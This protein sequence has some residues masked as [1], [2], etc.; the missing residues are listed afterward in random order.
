MTKKIQ[1][2]KKEERQAREII[3]SL[4][5]KATLKKIGKKGMRELAKK[6]AEAR[7]GNKWDLYTL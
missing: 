3:G 2:T 4:G 1:Y 5:G 7:W 6:G